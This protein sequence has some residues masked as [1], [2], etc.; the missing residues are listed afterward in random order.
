MQ[1]Q[2]SSLCCWLPAHTNPHS[3]GVPYSPVLEVYPDSLYPLPPLHCHP[4][5][6]LSHF[7]IAILQ[8]D[9]S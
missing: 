5:T 2:T 6:I 9:S 3:S 1:T 4:L 8:G 7:K